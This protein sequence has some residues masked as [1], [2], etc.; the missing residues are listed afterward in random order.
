MPIATIANCRV[1]GNLIWHFN[2]F[3]VT[4]TTSSHFYSR[5]MTIT[6]TITM[7]KPTIES[8]TLNSYTEKLPKKK[9]ALVVGYCGLGY[10]GLQM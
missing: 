2:N 6:T 5:N 9:V 10:Q 4:A 1:F 8:S 7:V 3:H